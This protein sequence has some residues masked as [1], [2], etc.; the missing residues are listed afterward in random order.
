MGRPEYGELS[1]LSLVSDPYSRIEQGI[2]QIDDEV[3]GDEADGKDERGAFDEGVVAG[4]QRVDGGKTDAGD[5]EDGL[6]HE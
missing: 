2:Q 4:R 6:D 1:P 3:D 5:A